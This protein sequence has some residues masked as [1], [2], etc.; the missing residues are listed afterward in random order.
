MDKKEIIAKNL[1]NCLTETNFEGLG[2][3]RKGKVRDQYAQ[4]DKMI[5]ITTDQRY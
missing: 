1:K 4:A 5:L 3:Y 2:K